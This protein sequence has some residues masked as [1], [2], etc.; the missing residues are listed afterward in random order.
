MLALLDLDPDKDEVVRLKCV[1]PLQSNV[2]VRAAAYAQVRAYGQWPMHRCVWPGTACV[3]CVCACTRVCVC[4]ACV[5]ACVCCVRVLRACVCVCLGGRVCHS[6]A[7]LYINRKRTPRPTLQLY[8]GELCSGT[9]LAFTLR[10]KPGAVLL[11]GDVWADAAATPSQ[12]WGVGGAARRRTS[13]GQKT[14][15]TLHPE[16]AEGAPRAGEPVA[17]WAPVL[18]MLRPQSMRGEAGGPVPQPP[19]PL[20]PAPPS[21]P[22]QAPPPLL[23]PWSSASSRPS[24]AFGSS[25]SSSSSGGGVVRSILASGS[26]SGG[27]SSVVSPSLAPGSSSSGSSGSSGSSSGGG[28]VSPPGAPSSA[29]QGG[30]GAGAERLPAERMLFE[31]RRIPFVDTRLASTAPSSILDAWPPSIRVTKETSV[32][33]PA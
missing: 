5:R 10:R 23:Q 25:S 15:F 26:S 4:V 24:L 29:A 22:P 14:V 31:L 9:S 28:V 6:R 11:G 32:R 16:G 3:C 8:A 1:T 27:S 33:V 21:L 20:L 12:G 7:S 17:W 18:Y 13:T 19:S 2:C 30:V